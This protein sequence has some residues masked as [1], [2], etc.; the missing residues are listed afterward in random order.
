[1]PVM[2]IPSSQAMS[3]TVNITPTSVDDG[4]VNNEVTDG[5]VVSCIA[6]NVRG[7]DQDKLY[8]LSIFECFMWILSIIM[9]IA[10]Y[11][12]D[13]VVGF[14]YIIDGHPLWGTMIILLAIASGIVV[15]AFSLYWS[16]GC[17]WRQTMSN[18]SNDVQES[19][20][21]DDNQIEISHDDQDN[22]E[23]NQHGPYFRICHFFGLS[24]MQR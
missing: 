24:M 17:C 20:Q 1:M 4:D 13:F 23:P 12:T 11:V 5:G 6:K 16:Y 10:D 2:T 19:Y 21:Q 18:D 9:Y 14:S 7:R 15:Q 8:R 22:I 3:E